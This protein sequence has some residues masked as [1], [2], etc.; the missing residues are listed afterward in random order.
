M[1]TYDLNERQESQGEQDRGAVWANGVLR[2]G[3]GFVRRSIPMQ[4]NAVVSTFKQ[5]YG[6]NSNSPGLL[7]STLNL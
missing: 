6:Q 5:A 4:I 7:L 1:G 2:H 3:D